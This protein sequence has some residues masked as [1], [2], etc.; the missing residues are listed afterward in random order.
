MLKARGSTPDG[1]AI[2]I[3]VERLTPGDVIWESALVVFGSIVD[4][5]HWEARRVG[6]PDG[7]WFADD[8]MREAAHGA[9]V[10]VSGRSITIEAPFKHS[11]G[12][13]RAAAIRVTCP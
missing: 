5:N 11:Q 13:T 9:L 8:G 3:E 10:G 7:R 1:K 12:E 6:H 4:D 2:A